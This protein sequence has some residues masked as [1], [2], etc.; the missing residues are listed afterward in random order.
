MPMPLHFPMAA[1][2]MDP[3]HQQQQLQQFLADSIYAHQP[4]AN[5]PVGLPFNHIDV[6]GSYNFQ[7]QQQQQQQQNQLA[8]L[9]AQHQQQR[10]SL[11]QDH[12]SPPDVKRPRLSSI[13]QQPQ[14]QVRA[15]AA[16]HVIHSN[17]DQ[18]PQRAP[19]ED[20]ASPIA[21]N[22]ANN[23]NNHQSRQTLEKRC[24]PF[25]MDGDGKLML[26]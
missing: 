25:A 14:L 9:Y 7:A 4:L 18:P 2:S 1:S 19:S 17:G 15:S 10:L 23:A 20:G 8:A 5:Q 21:L 13:T 12:C 3:M 16:N 24:R 6:G 26:A 22:D 11:Q